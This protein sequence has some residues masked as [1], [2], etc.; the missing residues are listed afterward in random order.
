MGKVNDTV[1][2]TKQTVTKKQ[3]PEVGKQLRNSTREKQKTKV[4]TGDRENE[5]GSEAKARKGKGKKAEQKIEVFST[6]K[7]RGTSKDENRDSEKRKRSGNN[8]EAE[9]F[10]AE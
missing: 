2:I 6:K 7:T 1:V 3:G 5:T 4:A 9:D 10:E 8:E